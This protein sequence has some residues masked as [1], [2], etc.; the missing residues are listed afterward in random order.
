[1]LSI[2]IP[3]YNCEKYLSSC[4]DFDINHSL[5]IVKQYNTIKKII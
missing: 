2:I 5:T 1:M 4:L 3:I